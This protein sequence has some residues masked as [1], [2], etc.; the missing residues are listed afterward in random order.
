MSPKRTCI[1]KFKLNNRKDLVRKIS[2]SI[3]IFSLLLIVFLTYS[4][5]VDDLDFWWHLKQ[6]QLIYETRGIPEKDYFAYTT[7]I[8]ET[9]S[10][11]GK[12]EVAPTELPAENTNWYWP[13][14]I[15][16]NWLSHLIFYLVYLLGGFIG[17]GILK[18][19]IFVFT[20]LVLYL[21]MLKR[22]A[23]YLSSFLVLC[24]VAYIGIDFNY[25]R[26]QIF[27]FLLFSCT[28]YILYDFRKGGKGI[29]FLPLIMLIWANLHGGF[30][31]GVLLIF[32]FSFT[33]LLKY[34]LKNRFGILKI[35]SL[36]KGEL[37]RLGL[38]LCIS[39]L[40]SLINPNGYKPF[41]F[42]FIQE[43]SLFTTIEEYHRP[44]LYEYHAYWFMLI[45]VII[46]III[47]IKMK[48]LDLTEL[49]LLVILTLPSLKSIRYI[50]FFALGSGVF[51]AHSMTHVGIQLK[52]WNPFKKLLDKPK[53]SRINMKSFLPLLLAVLSLIAL[54]KISISGEVLNFDMREK[55]Y[56]SGAVEFIQKNNIPGNMF[57]LYNWGGYLVWHL[58]PDYKVFFYGQALN[59]TA[60]FHYNQILKASNGT[61]PNMPLWK[62]LLTAYNVNFILTSAVSSSGNI[63]P[64]VDMLYESS[65]WELIYADGKSMIFLKAIPGNQDIIQQYKLS[66]EE[67]ENE[68]ISECEQ[69]IK[70]TPA[71]WGYYETLGFMYMKKNRFNEALS[72]FQKYLSMNPNN[73]TVRY[74]HE[75]LRQYLKQY[76]SK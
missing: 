30:I 23:G 13:T 15:K 49:F 71:T 9:I 56:P 28:L 48:R 11:I 47:L 50:I 40:A 27:S 39:I 35:S 32:T 19:T 31:L 69:G 42:P 17:I 16:R 66:K 63:I 20:Y 7:Y 60:F 73:K 76:N 5:K 65:D 4:N 1:N 33:E 75:L 55:R 59:E 51:L 21:T 10:K 18:S 8:P 26:P 61:D 68:V 72:M 38:V 25:T 2:Q 6:G 12:G 70:D 37:K 64:L 52:G 22:G 54:I 43:R 45:I 41:L 58:Y 53:F 62:R 46:F 29:Y 74:Y 24:L 44:M 14:T 67:I 3:P 36:N 34:L 57:N